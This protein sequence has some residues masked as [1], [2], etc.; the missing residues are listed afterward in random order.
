LLAEVFF[1]HLVAIGRA[2]SQQAWRCVS[3]LTAMAIPSAIV[4]ELGLPEWAR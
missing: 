2:N 4:G 3:V 1:P